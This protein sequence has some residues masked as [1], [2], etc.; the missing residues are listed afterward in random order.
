MGNL[1]KN[2]VLNNKYLIK[3]K[4]ISF[5]NKYPYNGCKNKKKKKI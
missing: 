4:S 5:I 2:K 1:A 3:I